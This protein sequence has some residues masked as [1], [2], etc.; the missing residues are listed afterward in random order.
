M[1]ENIRFKNLQVNEAGFRYKDRFHGFHEIARIFFNHGQGDNGEDG[2]LL[3]IFLD[4]GEKIKLKTLQHGLT[5]GGL[6]LALVGAN[7]PAKKEDERRTLERIHWLMASKSLD[8]RAAKYIRDVETTGF[9]TWG[10]CR[11]FPQERKVSLNGKDFY[12]DSCR[13]MHQGNGGGFLDIRP[14][15]FDFLDKVK[16]ELSVSST[17]WI[18]IRIDKDVMYYLLQKYFNIKYTV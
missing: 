8:K 1:P 17:P 12:L 4:S 16:R 13:I 3:E 7:D 2:I 14:N 10:K 6:F 11:F 9:F 15:D 5:P 18:D